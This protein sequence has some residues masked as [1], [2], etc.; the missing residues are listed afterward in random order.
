MVKIGVVL[1]QY[2]A[3]Y[4]KV[5]EMAV[6][7]E[8]LGYDSIWLEDH[9]M[10]WANDPKL[11]ALECWTTLTALATITSRIIIG[12]L[13]TCNSYRYPALVAKMAA[14]LDNISKGRLI[15]GIGAGWYEDEYNA[16]GIP[17]PRAKERVERL[18]EAVQ[19][20]KMLWTKERSS[21]KGKY[22]HLND[23]VCDPKPLQK[24]H[25][26][27]WIGGGGEKL[28]LK[29]VAEH[30]D[31]WN[32]GAMTP[33][34][35]RRKHNVLKQYCEEIGR[36]HESIL[37]S[38]ELFIFIGRSEREV[39][40]KVRRYLMVKPSGQKLQHLIQSAYLDTSI[41]STPER[42]AQALK[43]YV[44]AGVEHFTLVFP[45]AEFDSLRVFAEEVIPRIRSVT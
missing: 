16:Y 30:A 9:F 24:P 44:D 18:G 29:V 6:E 26:P 5:G 20:I 15:M 45:D 11:S 21:F 43:E 4:S 40:E 8:S 35:F 14:S 19:I 33:Q 1:P 31:G 7:C 36:G 2:A 32:Y 22:Y 12:T 23:A 13:C 34:E 25:P 17:Y 39:D 27:L 38:L 28:M 10:P 42:C 3:E 41:R 37:A